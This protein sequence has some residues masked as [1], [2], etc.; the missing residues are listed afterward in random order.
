MGITIREK[1]FPSA[2]KLCDI[3]YRVWTPDDP[4]GAVQIMHGMAEHLDRY[5]DFAMFL[6]N[7]G[8]LVYAMDMASHGK[9]KNIDKPRGFF[10]ESGGWVALIEDM[11]TLHD[12]VMKERAAL[13]AVLFGH[14]MGSFLARGYAARYGEDFQGFVFSGTAGKNPVA[15][16]GLMIV[17]SEI[18]KGRGYEPSEK[19]DKMSFGAYNKHFRNPRTSFDWLSS[20]TARVDAYVADEDCGFIFTPYGFETLLTSLIEV[21]GTSWASKVPDKPILLMSGACDPVGNMGKGVKQ[22][23]DWL[24]TTHH[25]VCMKLYPNGRHEMLNECNRDEVFSDVLLFLETIAVMGE[26][27]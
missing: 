26:L 23:N 9:S 10:G 1:H 24:E 12:L 3:R 27:A 17:H 5:E 13:P 6:A 16:L 21:S 14:S 18:R 2:T 11:H 7:N 4:R 19:L 20:D 22:V 15:R 25:Q 8:F